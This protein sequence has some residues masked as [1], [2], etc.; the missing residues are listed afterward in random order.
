MVTKEWIKDRTDEEIGDAKT[1]FD[2]AQQ[3]SDSMMVE[4]FIEM[5][6]QELWHAGNLFA[7]LAKN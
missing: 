6:R 4:T 5:G 1:Y 3:C 2:A 7:M